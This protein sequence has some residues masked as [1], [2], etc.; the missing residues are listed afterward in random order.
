[1]NKSNACV[2]LCVCVCV[3]ARMKEQA[4][5]VSADGEQVEDDASR[6]HKRA[7]EL[8]QFVRDTLLRAAGKLSSAAS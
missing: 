8:E 4:T 5:K 7:E 6:I 2:L 3:C 1:M